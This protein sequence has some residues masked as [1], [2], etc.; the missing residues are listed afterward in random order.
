MRVTC[1]AALEG[2][3]LIPSQE[4]MECFFH[5]LTDALVVPFARQA[6]E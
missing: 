4:N 3:R 6:Q 5:V 2:G 1:F